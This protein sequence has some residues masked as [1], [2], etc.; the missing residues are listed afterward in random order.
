[1]RRDTPVNV[2]ISRSAASTKLRVKEWCPGEP[3]RPNKREVTD[4]FHHHL[5]SMLGFFVGLLVPIE[6]RQSN[7]PATV[8]MVL[9][10]HTVS[11][12]VKPQSHT[13]I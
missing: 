1:M 7:N 10:N 6:E 11:G 13:I 9:K 12:T 3:H 4:C 5:L 2:I 8:S